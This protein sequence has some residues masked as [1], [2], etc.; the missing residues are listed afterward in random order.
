MNSICEYARRVYMLLYICSNYM[1]TLFTTYERNIQLNITILL[2]IV[3]C[4]KIALYSCTYTTC[5][6]DSSITLSALRISHPQFNSI[7][8]M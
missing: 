7:S 3:H 4:G 5:K 1:L 6:F 8:P 2:S